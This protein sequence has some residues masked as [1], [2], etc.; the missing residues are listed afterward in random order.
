MR[1]KFKTPEG[2]AV[3]VESSRVVA[4]YDKPRTH[5]SPRGTVLLLDGGHEIMV[6]ARI[7]DVGDR[8]DGKPL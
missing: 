1:T 8:L 2:V 5:I 3:W 7:G 4:Y 6:A